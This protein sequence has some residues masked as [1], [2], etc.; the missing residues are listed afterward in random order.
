M[1]E[2]HVFPFSGPNTTLL[3]ALSTRGTRLSCLTLP[4]AQP[5]GLT[6]S[7]FRLQ[8]VRAALFQE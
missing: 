5:Q 6:R 2:F 3:L 8:A 7:E 1:Y 4:P